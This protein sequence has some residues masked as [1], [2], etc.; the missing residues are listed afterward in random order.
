VFNPDNPLQSVADPTSFP[1]AQGGLPTTPAPAVEDTTQSPVMSA[2]SQAPTPVSALSGTD[3]RSLE[4]DAARSLFS[5]ALRSRKMFTIYF[6]ERSI[7]IDPVEA[8]AIAAEYGP[9]PDVP[10]MVP[11]ALAYSSRE[12]EMVVLFRRWNPN[13]LLH[14]YFDDKLMKWQPKLLPGTKEIQP[15]LSARKR[16][17]QEK[18][19]PVSRRAR[20]NKK[21]HSNKARR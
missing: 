13:F 19:K 1:V 6:G 15:I 16:L 21:M 10:W 20:R 14:F 4:L 5:L 12:E 7:V 3:L 9:E 8:Y 11:P 18:R 17:I 2:P